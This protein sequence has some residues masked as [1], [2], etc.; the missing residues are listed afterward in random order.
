MWKRVIASAALGTVLP[1]AA[2]LS[3][4][5][6]DAAE[7][8]PA[9]I[10]R[11]FPQPQPP[12]QSFVNGR[13]VAF[14]G[15]HLWTTFAFDP[16]NPD[17]RIYQLRT[18]GELQRT[19]DVG[20]GIGALAFNP[21]TGKLYGGAYDGSGGVYEIDRDTGSAALLFSYPFSFL[22]HCPWPTFPFPA[23][24]Y[25]DGLEYRPDA[26]SLLLS[27]DL[28][29][30]LFETDLSGNLISSFP[31]AHTGGTCNAGIAFDGSGYWLVD[32]NTRTLHT[33][34]SGTTDAVLETPDYLVEDT[35]FDNK[36]FAPL[37]AL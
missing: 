10:L 28:G 22:D 24:G 8:I 1:M 7:T 31:F 9:V 17:T 23:A 37:C 11:E 3:A 5:P 30:T 26:N 25:I 21:A 13:A 27:D 19:L 32:G 34:L 14:D 18:T 35:A 6:C 12:G 36:T 16:N 33:N 4:Y 20:V 2:V 29:Y 15:T